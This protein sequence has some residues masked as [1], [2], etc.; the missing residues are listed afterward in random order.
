D[1]LGTAVETA[2]LNGDRYREII[3]A[4][5]RGLVYIVDVRAAGLAAI[6]LAVSPQPAWVT[7]V[8][9]LAGPV[10]LAVG[11]VLGSETD[12]A[13]AGLFDLAIGDPGASGGRGAVY[14]V[15]GRVGAL[16]PSLVLPA[17]A[18]ASLAGADDGDR[19]GASVWI[20]DIDD[21]AAA[22]DTW[23]DLIA[24]APGGDGPGNAR[25]DAG[26]VHVVWGR[27][28]PAGALR[29]DFVV[30]GAAAGH[31]LGSEVA[32]G[33]VTRDT[34][35]DIV[36]LAPGANGGA[37]EAFLWFGR[38]RGEVPAAADLAAGVDRRIVSDEA[39][40][41]VRTVRVW[42]LTGEGAEEVLLG[43]PGAAEGAGR[44]DFAISP[45]LEISATALSV[46][47]VKCLPAASQEIVIGNPSTVAIPWRLYETPAWVRTVPEN[48]TTAAG[49]PSSVRLLID[50]SGLA[51]GSHTRALEI[52]SHGPD[53]VHSVGLNLTISVETHG[54]TGSDFDCRSLGL[55]T[56]NSGRTESPG[57]WPGDIPVTGD[58]DGDRKPDRAVFRPARGTWI[59]ETA[60]VQWGQPGDVPV[61][62]DYNGDGRTDVAVFRPS[63]GTWFVLNQFTIQWGAPGDV[64]VPAD[65][66]GDGR[67]DPAVYRRSDG[68]WWIRGQG[69]YQWGI[70]SDL[71]VPADYDG[72]GRADIAVFRPKTGRWFV[73]GQF[74]A[75]WGA[76]GDLPLP[77][78]ISGDGRADL[79]VYRRSDRLW[80]ALDRS[81]GTMRTYPAEIL[82]W[83]AHAPWLREPATISD[84]DGEGTGDLAVWR[85]G[86]GKWYFRYSTA[87]YASWGSVQWGL[88]ARG[89]VPVAADY[90]GDGRTDAA[91]WRAD[92][93]I[94]YILTSSSSYS[95]SAFRMFRWGHRLLGDIPVTGDFDGDGLADLTVWR[96]SEGLWWVRTSSSAFRSYFVVRWGVGGDVPVSADFDGDGCS[97]VAVWRPET[98]MWWVL[99]SG[100]DYT[101]YFAVRWGDGRLRDVAAASDYDGDRRADVAVWRAQTGTWWILTSSSNYRGYFTVQWGEGSLGDVP[102]V[103][104]Y[105]GDRRSDL[106]IWR[107]GS[108]VWFVRTS[109]SGYT[110]HFERQWGVGALGDVP[111]GQAPR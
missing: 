77:H 83:P 87:D 18:S 110:S 107:P 19:L 62:G 103:G 55:K 111:I 10:S 21:D 67:A 36:M 17:G 2:D 80:Y 13:G 71:P 90:D 66:D 100:S 6:D 93:G 53:V 15:H 4:T 94:W 12:A 97:D 28:G 9:G 75:A 29:A 59:F 39:A 57:G 95:H 64:P 38:S 11:N 101:G 46:R 108:G 85:P 43:V 40:G 32:A 20:A 63:T 1:G 72:D 61:P 54:S 49:A 65:Y 88:G 41:P 105:D 24:G 91:V 16:P 47:A 89:D 52:L 48:G 78:D 23:L 44:I 81:A 50:T 27:A 8:S 7:V 74:T 14:L 106:A 56:P 34:P 98:G 37:G 5:A 31:R 96:P 92:E 82:I 33:D 70:A 84:F 22:D 76:P 35:D 45:R 102:I 42:E 25:P 51:P 69:V 109:T 60:V 26:E 30:Y 86:E 58:Y 3:A 73:L 104:D 99:T 68:N 79:L